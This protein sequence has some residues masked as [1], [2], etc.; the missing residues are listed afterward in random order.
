MAASADTADDNLALV[1]THPPAPVA[2]VAC[3]SIASQLA[4]VGLTVDLREERADAAGSD[5]WDLRYYAAPLANP[6]GEIQHWLGPEGAAQPCSAAMLQA[7]RGLEAA[8]DKDQQAAALKSIH[9]L[10]A[11]ELPVIPL[12]QLVD[13]FAFHESVRGIGAPRSGLY[14]NVPRWQT[15]WRALPE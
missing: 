11:S 7:L 3:Q 13:H 1:L 14:E 4:V 12:W 9:R 10:A 15:E 5:D 2:R 8:A 6:A